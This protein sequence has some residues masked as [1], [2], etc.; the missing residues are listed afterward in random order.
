[1]ANQA[2]AAQQ[3]ATQSEQAAGKAIGSA[4]S[5]AGTALVDYLSTPASPPPP[6]TGG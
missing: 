5:T 3:R 4:V 2:S 6:P 1:M